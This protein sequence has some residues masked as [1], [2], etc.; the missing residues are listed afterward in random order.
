M[1]L[2]E[3][4]ALHNLSERDSWSSSLYPRLLVL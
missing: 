3:Q 4:Q 1:V 2:P